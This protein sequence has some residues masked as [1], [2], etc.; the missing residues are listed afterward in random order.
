M[1]ALQDLNGLPIGL[2]IDPG[3]N[4]GASAK[5]PILTTHTRVWDV[6][7]A[8]WAAPRLN[9]IGDGKIYTLGMYSISAAHFS[10]GASLDIQRHPTT[11]RTA[12][13]TAAGGTAIWTPAAGKKFRLMRYMIELTGNAIQTTAG[14]ITAQ[15]YDAATGMS[16]THSL[17][18]PATA[19]NTLGGSNPGW[20]DLGNGILS[21]TANNAL[22]M[23]LSAAITGGGLRVTV[24]GTE[25]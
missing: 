1:S 11:F 7:S 18:I 23:N 14:V 24:C 10:N 20:F 8:A 6:S 16:V 5:S 17:Y 12:L 21:A 9:A 19:V 3:D 22:N 2:T 13:V 25:E 15:F 4:S